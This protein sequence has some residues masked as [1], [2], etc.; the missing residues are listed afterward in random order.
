MTSVITSIGLQFGVLLGGAVVTEKVFGW[1]GIGDYLVTAIKAR[2]FM[3]VQSTVLVI[4]LSY[5]IVNLLI[6]L[7]YAL[8]NPKIKFN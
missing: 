3:V 6:D 4:A 8:I 1:P 5:V 2:D 7:L